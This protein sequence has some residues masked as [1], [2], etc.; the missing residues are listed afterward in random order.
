MNQVMTLNI[1]EME[2]VIIT[3]T[4][5]STMPC[6]IIQGQ[7]FIGLFAFPDDAEEEWST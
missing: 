4:M 3:I 1:V 2:A 6:F 5:T 7:N